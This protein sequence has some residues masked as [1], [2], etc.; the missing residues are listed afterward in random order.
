MPV[1]NR[2]ALKVFACCLLVALIAPAYGAEN[3]GDGSGGLN[4]YISRVK[5]IKQS[6]D[7]YMEGVQSVIKQADAAQN[8]GLKE[9]FLEDARRVTAGT[10]ED[11]RGISPPGGLKA[12]HEAVLDT[13]VYLNLSLDALLTDKIESSAK[14]YD[15]SM[16]SRLKEL[17]RLEAYLKREK[18][19]DDVIAGIKDAQ[20]KERSALQD[21]F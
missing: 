13:Y 1:L 10:I 18:A 11:L 19:P 7:F 6:A 2:A 21:S 15:Q 20:K 14:F 16:R 3:D 17:E 5:A 12:Y 8:R 4:E 9:T